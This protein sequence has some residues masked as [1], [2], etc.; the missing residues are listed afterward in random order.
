[1][2]AAGAGCFAERRA[3]PS[4]K[5]R[6]AV[7]ACQSLVCLIHSAAVDKLVYFRYQIVQGTAGRHARNHHT[8]LAEGNA[9][10]HTSVCLFFCLFHRC[11]IMK[12][13]KILYSFFDA[14]HCS[15]PP[16]AFPTLT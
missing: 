16:Y 6:E 10:V 4:G 9:A 14:F 5:F 3:D 13:L 1:M 12:F 8:R 7:G 11:H 2:H 15:F